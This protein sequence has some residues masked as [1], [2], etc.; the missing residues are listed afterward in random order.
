MRKKTAFTLVE[1]LVVIGIIA[2]LIGILLPALGRSRQ[3]ANSLWCLSNLRQ[4]G[5]AIS[6]YAN[7]NEDSLPIYYWNGWT[8]GSQNSPGTDWAWEIMPYIKPGAIGDY[9]GQGPAQLWTLFQDKDTVTPTE[10][11]PGLYSEQTYSIMDSM[12]RFCPGP[13]NG[14]EGP[15]SY[16]TALAKPGPQDDGDKPL[17]VEQVRRPGD[18]IMIMDAAQIGN[19]GNI[20]GTWA[21][22]ADF[23]LLQGSYIQNLWFWPG[24]LMNYCYQQY[25]QGPDAGLNQ[26]WINY[27]DMESAS[28]ASGTSLGNQLRFRH[29][30][31]TTTN[32]LFADGHAAS[33][34]YSHPG[35]GGC[36]IRWQNLILDDYR[37]D[38]IHFGPGQS[39]PY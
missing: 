33:F 15:L 25:P 1:L 12:C 10:F 20:N 35:S 18:M 30:N 19:E 37:L 21:T 34:H 22:D 24:G 9:S 2:L 38:D 31:N 11:N 3:Q 28:N 32:A 23:W 36:D 5:M 27:G 16:S 29:L 7:A 26:D 39:P 8:N 17:K 6:M 14:I 4:I 13:V